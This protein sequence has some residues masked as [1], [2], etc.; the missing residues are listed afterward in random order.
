MKILK[1][2][3]GFLLDLI[4]FGIILFAM[5]IVVVSIFHSLDTFNTQWQ[6][7]PNIPQV[8][9]DIVGVQAD[10]FVGVWD[11]WFVIA[12]LGYAIALIILAFSIKSHPVFA[13]LG[14][15]IMVIFGIIAVKLSNAF[16]SFGSSS[17]IASSADKFVFTTFV[18]NN[19]PFIVILFGILFIVI[20][21]AKTKNTQPLL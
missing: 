20:L 2:K 13:M 7:S 5:A 14:L 6:A 11:G 16:D 17:G 9:K 15:I 3:R 21:Y 19:L 12:V 10:R 8:S 4:S 1:S 18:I